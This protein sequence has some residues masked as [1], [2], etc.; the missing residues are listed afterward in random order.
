MKTTRKLSIAFFL[1]FMLT[2]RALG[3]GAGSVL[4][5]KGQLKIQQAE[6][7]KIITTPDTRVDVMENDRIH[8]GENTRA[9]V[10]MRGQKETVHLY[11][12]SFL[13]LTKVDDEKSQV[14]VLVGKA[15]F[16]V[17]PTVSKLTNLRRNFQIRTGNTFI[18]IRG[19]DVVVQTTG[20]VTDVL[21]IKGIVGVANLVNLDALVELKKNQATRTRGAEPPIPAVTVPAAAVEKVLATDEP[22]AWEGVEL[23]A[24]KPETVSQT[25]AEVPRDIVENVNDSVEDA[26]EQVQTA[27]SSNASIKFKVTEKE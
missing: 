17:E 25:P 12:R 16:V 4:L 18:G 9:K 10:T 11:A 27:A 5:L 21:T 8:T 14:S 23:G 26:R 6:G 24:E 7:F 22:G 15:R 1:L 2:I 13:T 19:T 20:N 3:A